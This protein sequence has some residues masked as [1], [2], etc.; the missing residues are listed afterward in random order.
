MAQVS[1]RQGI[2]FQLPIRIV[3]RMVRE[4]SDG[5][6]WVNAMEYKTL[7]SLVLDFDD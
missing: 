4:L 5:V 3:N 7:V 6:R 2:V 1:D